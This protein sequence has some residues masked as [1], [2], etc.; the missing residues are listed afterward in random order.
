MQIIANNFYVLNLQVHYSS[1]WNAFCVILSKGYSG[2][3]S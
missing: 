2:K 3:H 1:S